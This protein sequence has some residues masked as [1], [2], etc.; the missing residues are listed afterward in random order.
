MTTSDKNSGVQS[1]G[2]DRRTVLATL[3]ASGAALTAGAV[4][5]QD[6]H[7]HHHGGHDGHA[8]G[9]GAKHQALIEAAL[10]CVKRGEVCISH[11]ISL[12][13][14]GDT[15]LK[16]CLRSVLTMLPSCEALARVAALDA[17]RLKELAKVCGDICADCQAECKK[18][19]D[20]H[21]ACK[22]CGEACGKCAEECRKLA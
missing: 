22:A 15:S 18:H 10:D 13:G 3:A 14:Q 7:E 8:S 4:Q 16:D 12:L 5:A 11:C 6:G 2:I 19:Q 1:P 20:H 9:E 17:P 21:A